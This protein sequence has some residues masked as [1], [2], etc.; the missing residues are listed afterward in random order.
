MLGLNTFIYTLVQIDV[1]I[2]WNGKS[3]MLIRLFI[4]HHVIDHLLV[5]TVLLI[6]REMDFVVKEK[7]AQRAKT[8]TL[9]QL[10]RNTNVV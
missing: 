7:H 4:V 2:V 6:T 8:I 1:S 3:V 9:Y 10:N 5:I